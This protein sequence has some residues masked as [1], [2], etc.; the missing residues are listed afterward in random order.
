MVR[1]YYEHQSAW[2]AALGE[3]LKCVREVRNCSD[4]FAVAIKKAG[5]NCRI[6]A[7]KDIQHLLVILAKLRAKRRRNAR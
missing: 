1:G 7:Y 4:V 3:K 2:Q 6:L 5:I